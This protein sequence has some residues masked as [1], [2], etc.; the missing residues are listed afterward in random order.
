MAV[1]VLSNVSHAVPQQKDF[2]VV[3]EL[4]SSFIVTLDIVFML[5]NFLLR[6]GI[7]VQSQLPGKVSSY[8]Q[9][10]VIIYDP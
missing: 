5:D 1:L 8:K 3:M 6:W 4:Y 9:V 7:V 2:Q 10:N